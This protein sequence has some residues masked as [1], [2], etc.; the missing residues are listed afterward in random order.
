MRP[1]QNTTR[2]V[3]SSAVRPSMNVGM[4]GEAHLLLRRPAPRLDRGGCG[5]H[6]YDYRPSLSPVTLTVCLLDLDVVFPRQADSDSGLFLA[7][8]GERRMVAQARETE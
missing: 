7:V 8:K 3:L 4:G 1:A 2:A 6:D 5:S